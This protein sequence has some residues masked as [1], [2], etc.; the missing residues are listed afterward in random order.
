MRTLDKI[1]IPLPCTHSIFKLLLTTWYALFKPL[2]SYMIHMNHI[3]SSIY[4]TTY[5]VAS[6]SSIGIECTAVSLLC[7][8]IVSF[9]VERT[10]IFY[11]NLINFIL[12]QFCP[13]NVMSQP[14]LFDIGYWQSYKTSLAKHCS[15]TKY[16]II[17]ILCYCN[18]FAIK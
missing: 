14:L 3:P 16:K 1:A 13:M 7:L 18:F 4:L 10:S 2:T 5:Q 9:L 17:T 8:C 15:W 6:T 12:A 11:V